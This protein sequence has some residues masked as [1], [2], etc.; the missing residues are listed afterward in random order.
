MKAVFDAYPNE[1]WTD[2]IVLRELIFETAEKTEGFGR[3]TETLKWGQLAYLTLAP[4]TGRI[5]RIDALKGEPRRFALFIHCQTRL[6]E[7]FIEHY[8]D[9]F[10][11]DGK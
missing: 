6:M 7:M 1:V 5:I 8:P 2:L 9:I 11:V 3:L 4:K 10:D